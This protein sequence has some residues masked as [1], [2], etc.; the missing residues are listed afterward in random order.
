MNCFSAV[1][2]SIRICCTEK[3]YAVLS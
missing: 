2:Y 1:V 3:S